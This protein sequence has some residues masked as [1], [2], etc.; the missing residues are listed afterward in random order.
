MRQTSKGRCQRHL[1]N[2]AWLLLAIFALCCLSCKNSRKQELQSQLEALYGREVE[3]CTERMREFSP[4][5]YSPC[6]NPE[7]PLLSVVSFVDSTTC[8]PCAME[9]LLSW[10]EFI[11]SLDSYEGRIGIYFIFETSRSGLRDA[12]VKIKLG[13]DGKGSYTYSGGKTNCKAGGDEQ[14]TARYCPALL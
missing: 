1:L 3:L 12:I 11:D 9:N 2:N 5:K 6:G 10:C 7:H 13:A 14:C 8:S 4:P